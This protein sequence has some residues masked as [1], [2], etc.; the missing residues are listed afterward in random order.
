MALS[1]KATDTSPN[2]VPSTLSNH[3]RHR[4][5]LHIPAVLGWV[6]RVP[7]WGTGRQGKLT[8]A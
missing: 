1:T 2:R 4:A 5:R 7:L 3:R 6:S 8:K